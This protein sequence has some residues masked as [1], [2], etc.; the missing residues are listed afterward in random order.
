MRA[1]ARIRRHRRAASSSIPG[2]KVDP[3]AYAATLVGVVEEGTTVVIT[4][5]AQPRV[6]RPPTPVDFTDLA[7]DV[8]DWA[9]GGHSLGGVRACQ[10]AEGTDGLVLFGSYCANDLS[11]SGLAVLSIS[12]SED[13]LSTPEKIDDV[14][15]LLP[16]D[17]ISSRSRAEAT[18]ASATTARS[19]A[20]ATRRSRMPTSGRRSPR[21]LGPFRGQSAAA[22]RGCRARG[23]TCGRRCS[24]GMP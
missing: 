3:L 4:K 14:R 24:T 15:H 13:G 21:R 5:P 10:L 12:A 8:D 18:P 9:V 20:T 7:P 11:E 22:S 19:R 17:T 6:L 16:A 1:V 23:L 2:A